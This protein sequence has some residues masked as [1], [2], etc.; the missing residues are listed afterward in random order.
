[1]HSQ[2]S[3]PPIIIPPEFRARGRRPSGPLWAALSVC[4]ALAGLVGVMA[5]PPEASVPEVSPVRALENELW[6]NLRIVR[7]A[8][9]DYRADRGRWPSAEGIQSS[10]AMCEHGALGCELGFHEDGLAPPPPLILRD[11]HVPYLPHGI[12]INPVNDLRTVLIL[13]PTAEMPAS[14]DGSTGWIYDPRSG[15]VRSNVARRV[16]GR[17]QRYFDL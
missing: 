14:P 16:H 7:A 12:P 5:A 4:A 10:G 11:A 6:K 17:T 13:E 15:E 9:A 8:I 3:Q 2:V 1:M